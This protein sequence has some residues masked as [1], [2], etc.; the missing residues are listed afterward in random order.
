MKSIVK[1]L[2][3]VN[4]RLFFAILLLMLFP[5]I[6]QTVRIFFL[7]DMPNDW[8]FNI[9]SQ[10]SW[11]SLFYEIIQEA[12]ILPLFFV[13]GKSLS[14]KDEFINKIKVG[15]LLTGII[16]FVLSFIL[17]V[18]AKPIVIFMAQD[19]KLID[20]TVDYIRLE[21]VAA[22][23][24]TL[25]KFMLTV[26]ITLKKD[27]YMYLTLIVQMVLSVLLDTFLVSNLSISLKI[28]VNGIAITNIIVNC[29]NLLICMLLLK[30]EN[31]SIL[32]GGKL[33]FAWVKEWF[34]VGKFSGIESLIRNVVF[35]I[36]I[37][38]MV[39]MVSEQGSYWV[40]NNFIWNWLL[41][42][43]LALGDL[44]KK[45]VGEDKTNIQTKTFGYIILTVIFTILWIVSIPVW[46]P[47]LRVIMNID[48]YETVYYIVLIQTVFYITFIF[49]HIC[50]ST[51]YGVGRTDYMLIQSICI[52]ICYYG[53]A[54]ILY[55]NG[56]F[57]PSLLSISLLFGIGMATD[58]IPTLI[59]YFRMLKKMN[60]KIII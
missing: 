47:F 44:I 24:S 51:F 32:T 10:L 52:D 12:L 59:L 42:P 43:A 45:E 28:G 57:V 8:G 34:H 31:M 11:V 23:L 26:L 53:I 1:A 54:F 60:M 38:R 6:Y 14:N 16:Y 9:A 40:A 17:F 58:F 19:K 35:S 56:I 21:T 41:L 46:K 20:A 5:T 30:K 2:K 50:D 29:I 25:F 15:I 18:F 13:L 4:Y 55:L 39:N 48:V 7:G 33:S 37:I 27:G 3:S 22:L 49:N 36:M